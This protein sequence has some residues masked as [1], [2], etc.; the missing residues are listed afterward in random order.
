MAKA[1]QSAVNLAE[2][3]KRRVKGIHSQTEIEVS[4][5]IDEY[6]PKEEGLDN[7]KFERQVTM[8]VIR[9]T[10]EAID[11]KHH[12]Y[13]EPVPESE[14]VAYEERQPGEGGPRSRSVGPNDRR[15][16]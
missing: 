4:S 11:S 3:V 6:E 16:D 13:Q 14:V 9:L 5:L 1:M 15:R 2:L 12:G 10:K 7:L 8:I